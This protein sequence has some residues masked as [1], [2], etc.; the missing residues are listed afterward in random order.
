MKMV[1]SSR[2]MLLTVFVA[3][4]LSI[5]LVSRLACSFGPDDRRMVHSLNGSGGE[6]SYRLWRGSLLAGAS[7]AILVS[8]V[9]CRYFGETVAVYTSGV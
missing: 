2:T 8:G 6:L 5:L 1:F 7:D 9:L 4:V 3:M